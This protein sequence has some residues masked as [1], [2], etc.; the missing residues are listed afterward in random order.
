MRAVR[1]HRLALFLTTLAAAALCFQ[2]FPGDTLEGSLVQAA[3]LAALAVLAVALGRPA[4]LGLS[5]A[6]RT[7]AGR[8]AA[9][10]AQAGG[11]GSAEPNAGSGTVSR[12][13]EADSLSS[14][15]GRGR[16]GGLGRWTVA[17]L[18][19]GALAGA[20]SWWTLAGGAAAGVA[21]DA[22]SELA[23][24][25][26]CDDGNVSALVI[27]LGSIAVLCLL[28]GVFE[29]GVFRVLALDALAPAF[30][31]NRRACAD[32]RGLPRAPGSERGAWQN[33]MLG[34]AVAS[35]ALFGILHVSAMD[36]AAAESAVAWAQFVL[37]P[38]QAALFGFFMA[39]LFVRTGSLWTV[40][41]VHGLFNM[42]YTGPVL[43]AGVLSPTYV[44]GNI[45]DLALLAATVLLLMPPALAAARAFTGFS[46]DSRD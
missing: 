46:Q 41:G 32:G 27:R 30:S 1:G 42:L 2:V 18:A 15:G 34:A 7:G 16:W 3:V 44:T 24:V 25:L 10:R 33:G 22:A 6:R 37:K 28:T 38:V 45:V 19:I 36:A 5:V 23:T 12:G 14:S 20:A 29:E 21:G 13:A 39:A 40:A 17:V 4:A 43:A 31:G 26:S 8:A 35:S 9:C 11:N